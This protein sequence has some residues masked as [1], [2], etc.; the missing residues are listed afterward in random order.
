MDR[1]FLDRRVIITFLVNCETRILRFG[2][3]AKLKEV[4]ADY[5]MASN[6]DVEA[7]LWEQFAKPKQVDFRMFYRVKQSAASNI[8]LELKQGTVN[9]IDISLGGAKFTCSRD[10]LLRPAD[11]IKINLA[12]GRT[13]FNLKARVGDVRTLRDAPISARNIQYVSI[14]FETGNTQMENVLGKAII[15]MERQLLSEGKL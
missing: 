13:V 15:E 12:V 8:R 11:E 9:L 6:K 14:Q 1:H 10:Y 5:Q 4:M 7:L 2:F 3:P